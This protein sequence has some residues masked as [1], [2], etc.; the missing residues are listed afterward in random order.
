MPLR[1][2]SLSRRYAAVCIKAGGSGVYVRFFQLPEEENGENNNTAAQ[3]YYIN[4][5]EPS[6]TVFCCIA[7]EEYCAATY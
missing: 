7:L 2:I 5:L 6:A 4:Q 3:S 1:S